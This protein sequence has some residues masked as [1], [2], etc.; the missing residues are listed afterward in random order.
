MSHGHCRIWRSR[1]T[2]PPAG[3]PQ[4]SD[5]QIR[6]VTIWV[7]LLVGTE[8]S[9]SSGWATQSCP[10][11]ASTSIFLGRLLALCRW[12]AAT[13]LQRRTLSVSLGD[14][15]DFSG[16]CVITSF[17]RVPSTLLASWYDGFS[18]VQDF[19]EYLA[20]VALI[21]TRATGPSPR[22]E[23][24]AGS[25]ACCTP[26]I[27]CCPF[28]PFAVTASGAAGHNRGEVAETP[29][30]A[31]TQGRTVGCIFNPFEIQGCLLG[32]P[33]N[34]VALSSSPQSPG[35]CLWREKIRTEGHLLGKPRNSVTF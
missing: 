25:A 9:L 21:F 1:R 27:R 4:N 19:L 26:Y 20:T 18:L 3:C 13:S 33:R 24:M 34:S 6:S 28:S 7:V 16:L 12:R 31:R 14:D 11:G 35:K 10:P 22:W 32:I 5:S 15:G 8:H 23:P 30:L 29:P 2:P 17:R